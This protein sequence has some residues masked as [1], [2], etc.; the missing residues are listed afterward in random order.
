MR[1]SLLLVV[2]YIFNEVVFLG[3]G[4]GQVPL[5]LYKDNNNFH[6]ITVIDYN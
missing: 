5:R 4:Q 1:I 3:I 2:I 6:L